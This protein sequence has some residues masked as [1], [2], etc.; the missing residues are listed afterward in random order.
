[1]TMTRTESRHRAG[2]GRACAG[3]GPHAHSCLGWHWPASVA[4]QGSEVTA[5]AP[6]PVPSCLALGAHHGRGQGAAHVFT[7]PAADIWTANATSVRLAA[8]MT[9]D[10]LGNVAL[11]ADGT[12]LALGMHDVQP[13]G[14]AFLSQRPAD[15]WSANASLA[16]L[17]ANNG[18]NSRLR[19][20]SVGVDDVGAAVARKAGMVDVWQ[21]AS[22]SSGWSA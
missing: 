6:V 8:A 15:G 22:V 12:L 21:R 11:N 10:G 14:A 5:G 19:G 7:R 16:P 13:A 3:T 2:P 20:S 1:V 4:E 17:T 9:Y 18:T